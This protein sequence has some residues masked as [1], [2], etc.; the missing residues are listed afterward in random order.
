MHGPSLLL[1]YILSKGCSSQDSHFA[2]WK[3][4]GLSRGKSQQRPE[5][6]LRGSTLKGSFT[7]TKGAQILALALGQFEDRA[8]A[9]GP[10]CE[11]TAVNVSGLIHEEPIIQRGAGTAVQVRFYAVRGYPE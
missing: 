7:R 4:G 11:L 2:L 1:F 3:T 6:R 10:A 8:S 5:S 9:V